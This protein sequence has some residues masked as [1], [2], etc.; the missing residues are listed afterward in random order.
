[1]NAT[2]TPAF[3]AANSAISYNG[4]NAGSTYGFHQTYFTAT[5]REIVIDA[6]ITGATTFTTIHSI[7]YHYQS[8]TYP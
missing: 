6:T 7:V 5:V 3:V 1:M 2:Y 4:T 8:F